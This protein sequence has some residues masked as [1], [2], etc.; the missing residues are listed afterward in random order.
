MEGSIRLTQEYLEERGLVPLVLDVKDLDH[1]LVR[2][3]HGQA[4]SFEASPALF[5]FHE[6]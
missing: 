1:T 4:S 5:K 6:T 2:V 3:L